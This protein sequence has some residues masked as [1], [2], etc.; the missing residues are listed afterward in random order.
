ME[1]AAFRRDRFQ[2]AVTRLKE[3]LSEVK[4]LEED[5]RR[6]MAYEK[7]KAERDRLAA[8]LKA[9]YPSIEA[10][11][12]ELIPKIEANDRRVAAI[13]IGRVVQRR[14]GGLKFRG[15]APESRRLALK[16]TKQGARDYRNRVEVGC[17]NSFT[18]FTAAARQHN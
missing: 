13:A 17:T 6:R 10:Q 1:D 8:G 3:R 5:H 7:T 12:G 14:D 11:L 4:A 16:P 9:R 2:T 15:S 18:R